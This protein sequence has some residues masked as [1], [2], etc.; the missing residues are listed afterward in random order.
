[1]MQPMYYGANGGVV[2]TYPVAPMPVLRDNNGNMVLKSSAAIGVF[3][4]LIMGISFLWIPCIGIVFLVL[5]FKSTTSNITFNSK[6][7]VLE[8]VKYRSI[9]KSVTARKDIPYDSVS[10]VECEVVPGM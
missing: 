1:M 5:A 10:S 3:F 4:Y 6:R 9:S 2:T 7:R 8:V